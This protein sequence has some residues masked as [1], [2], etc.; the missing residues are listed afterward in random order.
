MEDG[1]SRWR[2]RNQDGRQEIKMEDKIN[3]MEDTKSR[4]RIRNKDGG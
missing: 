3:K 2:I 4:W 1:K